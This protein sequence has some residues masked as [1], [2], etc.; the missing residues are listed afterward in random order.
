MSDPKSQ[1]WFSKAQ[2]AARFGVC[3]KSI[4]RWSQGGKFPVGRQLPNTRWVWSVA[5]IEAYERSL[6]AAAA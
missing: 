2:V 1:K 4:E 3:Q 5:E 6:T